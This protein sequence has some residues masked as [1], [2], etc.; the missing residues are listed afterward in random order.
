MVGVTNVCLRQCLRHVALFGVGCYQVN[1][2]RK[3]VKCPG[4]RVGTCVSQP[5]PEFASY[6]SGTA[7]PACQVTTHTPS[8]DPLL[9]LCP[10]EDPILPSHS[11]RTEPL[12]VIAALLAASIAYKKTHRF[13]ET[14]G[15][16][17]VCSG[18]AWLTTGQ[19]I[20][21][22]NAVAV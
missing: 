2:T 1:R 14:A 13:F 16:A 17:L 10:S 3:N 19:P 6:L 11:N 5:L 21:I 9:C 12:L 15:T 22:M 4:V 18:E 7:R 8:H 20:F